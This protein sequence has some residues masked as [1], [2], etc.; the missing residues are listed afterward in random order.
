MQKAIRRGDA[1]LGGYGAIELFESGFHEYVWRRLLKISVEDCWGIL[2]QEVGALY[3]AFKQINAVRN[4]L[5]TRGAASS[6]PRR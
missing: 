6:S 5:A 4:K 1:R 2:T 3:A